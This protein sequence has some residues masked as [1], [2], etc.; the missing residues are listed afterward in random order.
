MQQ[1]LKNDDIEEDELYGVSTKNNKEPI[2][3]E[4]VVLP[5]IISNSPQ[6]SISSYH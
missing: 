6:R 2:K 4:S 3:Y 1:S 5:S